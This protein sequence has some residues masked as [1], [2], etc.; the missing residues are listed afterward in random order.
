MRCAI[1]ADRPMGDQRP[2]MRPAEAVTRTNPSRQNPY[3]RSV[4]H[5]SPFPTH[6]PQTTEPR[7]PAAERR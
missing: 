6:Q 7:A 4:H 2:E 3:Q 1:P 5:L